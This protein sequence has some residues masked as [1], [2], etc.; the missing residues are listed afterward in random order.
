VHHVSFRVDNLE[1]ALDFYEGLLGCVRL[2]RPSTV[3]GNGAW[4]QAGETQVHL[5]EREADEETGTPPTAVVSYANHVAFH[6]ED[7]EAA[8]AGFRDR[9]IEVLTSLSGLPQFFVRDPTGNVIE[10]TAF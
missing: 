9:G 8:E 4:L 5:M 1:Q 7:I 10:F 3:I 2:H 6:T